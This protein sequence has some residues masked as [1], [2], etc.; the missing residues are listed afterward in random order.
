MANY[1]FKTI[2]K[3]AG[4]A[5]L[6]HILRLFQQIKYSNEAMF[7]F[8][9]TARQKTTNFSNPLGWTLL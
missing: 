2:Y 3:F 6:P 7:D 5:S 8:A 4:R 1:T 9:A